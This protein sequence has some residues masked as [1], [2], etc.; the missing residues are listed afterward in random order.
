MNR[1]G[2]NSPEFYDNSVQGTPMEQVL[3]KPL[4]FTALSA[5]NKDHPYNNPKS[6]QHNPDKYAKEVDNLATA[7]G[8]IRTNDKNW[9]EAYEDARKALSGKLDDITKGALFY[10]NPTKQD[11][12]RHLKERAFLT[13]VGKHH[14]YKSGGFVDK[15]LDTAA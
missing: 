14:F 12:P 7:F 11:M 6:K 15:V 8:N 3:M 13:S 2:T 5:L 1:V 10:Y 9:K 4:A